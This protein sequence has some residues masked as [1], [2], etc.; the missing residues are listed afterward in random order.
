MSTQKEKDVVLEVLEMYKNM[1]FLWDRNHEDYRNKFIRNNGKKILLEYYRKLD[2]KTS[3]PTFTKKILNLR[4][5]YLKELRKVKIAQENGEIYEPTLWYYEA[6]SFLDETNSSSCCHSQHKNPLKTEGNNTERST[7]PASSDGEVN[8][9]I[10]D[11]PSSPP[12]KKRKFTNPIVY[13]SN[14]NCREVPVEHSRSSNEEWEIYGKAIGLQ[15]RDLDKT[16]LTIA[17]KIISDAIYYAKFG[18][19]SQATYINV[20]DPSSS[21]VGDT[22]S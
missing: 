16:Q 9:Q 3:M 8:F 18:L 7:S 17:R 12:V 4:S 10:S 11:T 15:L 6:L 21:N 2:E 20:G 14:S 13:K 19:L 5:N 22:P 1:P